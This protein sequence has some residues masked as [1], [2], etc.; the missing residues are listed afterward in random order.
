MSSGRIGWPLL[1]YKRDPMVQS[2]EYFKQAYHNIRQTNFNT[3]KSGRGCSQS[4]SMAPL[5]GM[6]KCFI[7]I[8]LIP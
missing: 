2:Q 1:K 5:G 8:R 4:I 6:S 7:C 3:C